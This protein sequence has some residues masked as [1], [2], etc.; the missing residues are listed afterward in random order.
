MAQ[1]I[2]CMVCLEVVHAEVHGLVI[3]SG[4]ITKGPNLDD[5][6]VLFF[7]SPVSVEKSVRSLMTT[8]L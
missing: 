2:E 5:F 7:L 4:W 3:Q 6:L 8:Q 1:Q